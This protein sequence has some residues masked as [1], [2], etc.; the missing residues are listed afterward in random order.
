MNKVIR[1][2]YAKN[3]RALVELMN[4]NGITRNDIIHIDRDENQ[5]YLVYEGK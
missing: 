1:V 5:I 4:N 3:Y 2:T